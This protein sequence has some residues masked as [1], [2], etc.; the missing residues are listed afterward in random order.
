MNGGTPMPENA[1]LNDYNTPGNYYCYSDLIARTIENCPF[2]KAFTLKVEYSTGIGYPCQSVREYATGRKVY[3]FA[4]TGSTVWSDWLYF[5]DDATVLSGKSGTWDPTLTAGVTVSGGYGQYYKIGKLVYCNVLIWI[6]TSQA[7]DEELTISLPFTSDYARAYGTV[8]YTA[9][10][11]NFPNLCV[12][13]IGN[14][15]KAQLFYGNT[16]GTASA[17]KGNQISTAIQ[18]TIMYVTSE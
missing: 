3:R 18:F 9:P 1:N 15:N 6:D 8:G 11:N 4:N 13:I 7:T 17:I 2:T 14:D 12:G 16:S 5:S 10:L